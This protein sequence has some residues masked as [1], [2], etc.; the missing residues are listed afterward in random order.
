MRWGYNGMPKDRLVADQ[1]NRHPVTGARFAN[2]LELRTVKNQCFLGFMAREEN[3][4]VVD[5]DCAN[6]SP[7][8][9]LREIVQAFDVSTRATVE[10][11]GHVGAK[12]R[13]GSRVTAQD[14]L[15]ADLGFIRDNLDVDLE[16]RLGFATVFDD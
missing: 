2:P 16:T 14:I 4:I 13:E 15:P 10:V 12:G 5:C 8:Q 7:E 6:A 11:P 3:C 1:I 9:M